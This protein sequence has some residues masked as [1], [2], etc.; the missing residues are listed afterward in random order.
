MAADSII[1][2]T[3]YCP[4]GVSEILATSFDYCIGR[5]DHD[6]VL[7]YLHK[8]QSPD[9]EAHENITV[10]ALIYTI[11]GHHKQFIRFKSGDAWHGLRL[12]YATNGSATIF[13]TSWFKC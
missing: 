8:K 4:P 7:K 5:I 11:L 13:T 12:E 6:T 9:V 3:A 1:E 10:E 2:F